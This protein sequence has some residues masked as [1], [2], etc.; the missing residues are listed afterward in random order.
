[1]FPIAESDPPLMQFCAILLHP[2]IDSQEQSLAP[3]CVSPSQAATEN[4]GHL[5]L[6]FSSLDS[7]VSSASPHLGHA[8]QHCCQHPP[9]Y[10]IIN[11]TYI[12]KKKKK[13]HSYSMYIFHHFLL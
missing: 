3:C 12:K 4:R 10:A 9:L 6:L 13:Q 8:F 1:M 7:P 2:A 11:L 5:C